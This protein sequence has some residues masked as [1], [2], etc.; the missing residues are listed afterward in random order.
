MGKT[1]LF[2]D[3]NKPP[4][5]PKPKPAPPPVPLVAREHLFHPEDLEKAETTREGIKPLEGQDYAAPAAAPLPPV[6]LPAPPAAP[7]PQPTKV[8]RQLMP[9][10]VTQLEDDEPPGKKI[11]TPPAS[12]GRKWKTLQPPPPSPSHTLRDTLLLSL[13]AIALVLAVVILT[14]LHH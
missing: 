11:L 10:R 4:T 7:D 12:P 1:I 9:T 6:I 2:G 8:K 14:L 3:A 5:A 13:I